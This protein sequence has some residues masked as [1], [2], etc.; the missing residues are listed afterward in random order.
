MRPLEE[1]DRSCTARALRRRR[2]DERRRNTVD[3]LETIGEAAA[4][5]FLR[6]QR[7]RACEAVLRI[8]PCLERE[9]RRE[10]E[11][12][13]VVRG[14]VIADAVEGHGVAEPPGGAPLL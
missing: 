7:A 6:D 8:D 13:R 10:V 9:R 3:E 5:A 2:L 11:L 4:R 12:G 14:D 1:R